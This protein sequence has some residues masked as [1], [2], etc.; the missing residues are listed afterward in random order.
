MLGFWSFRLRFRAFLVPPW[1]AGC[2]IISIAVVLTLCCTAAASA[3]DTDC[4]KAAKQQSLTLL[5]AGSRHHVRYKSK[6]DLNCIG[7]RGIGKG[8]DFYSMKHE[9]SLGEEMAKE[10]DAHVQIIHDPEINAYVDHLV[11]NIAGHSDAQIL[12]SVKVVKDDE[13][14]AF[15]LPGG[16]LYVNTGL[17]LDVPDEATLAGLLAHEVAHVAARHGTKILTK[18]YI[19]KLATIPV[20]FAG[21]AALA[22]TNVVGP[23]LMMRFSRD[24]ERE[25]DLLGIEYTYAAG[26]DPEGFVRFFENLNVRTKQKLPLVVRMFATHPVSQ[27]RI[28]RAQREIESLLPERSEYVLDT[29]AFD[30]MKQRLYILLGGPCQRADGRPVLLGPTKH[31]P[32]ATDSGQRPKLAPPQV[33]PQKPKFVLER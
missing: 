5:D 14:N 27:D 11:Q 13:I 24:A 18:R 33:P 1:P 19:F 30:E 6:Y 17:I 15:S 16:F 28:R 4:T 2:G 21:S 23:M 8:L 22:A 25:A 10:I 12:F 32:V 7:D 20:R 26:Y 31:C 3:H 29:S 9:R